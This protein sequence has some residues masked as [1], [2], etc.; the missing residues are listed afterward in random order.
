MGWDAEM[1]RESDE[2]RQWE[3]G[4]GGCRWEDRSWREFGEFVMTFF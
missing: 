3:G 1:E 2:R 4:S